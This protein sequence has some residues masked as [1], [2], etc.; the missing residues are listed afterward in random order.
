MNERAKQH[1]TEH[2]DVG[3][4]KRDVNLPLLI[5]VSVLTLVV[6]VAALVLLSQYFVT[7]KEKVVYEMVLQPESS[8]LRE[9]RA[10][11]TE[12]LNSYKL[13]D[14]TK[15]VYR[16]P[17]SRAMELMAEETYRDDKEK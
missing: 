2:A 16:I 14:S 3:Y 15:G 5:I 7:A 1:H 9:L 6:I 8:A 11:E 4:E 17:I 13:L 12:I 10:R